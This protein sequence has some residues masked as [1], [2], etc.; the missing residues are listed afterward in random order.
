MLGYPFGPVYRLIL[1]TG[2]RQG[3]W[4]RC[5]R[6]CIDIDEALL[7]LPSA[8]YKSDHVHIVPLVPEAVDILRP[9]LSDSPCESGDYIFSVS[10]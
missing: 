9:I 10:G 7:V 2:C 4:S 8:A 3:K 1:L 5:T 6:S